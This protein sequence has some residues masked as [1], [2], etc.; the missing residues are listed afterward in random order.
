[1]KKVK[2][3]WHRLPGEVVEILR[4]KGGPQGTRKGGRGYNRAKENNWKKHI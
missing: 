3:F 1:M 4:H 2:K